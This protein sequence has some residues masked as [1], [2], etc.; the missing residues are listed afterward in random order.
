MNRREMIAVSIVGAGASFVPAK[1]SK[2]ASR[3][4]L[5]SEDD[6]R[7]LATG[8]T[9]WSVH[10]DFNFLIH[11]RKASW[12]EALEYFAQPI[13]K[14][15]SKYY[16]RS[17]YYPNTELSPTE[18]SASYIFSHDVCV[19]QKMYSVN[20]HNGIGGGAG[21][22]LHFTPYLTVPYFRRIH[23]VCVK[24]YKDIEQ[25]IKQKESDTATIF[26]NNKPDV[27]KDIV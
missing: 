1:I 3:S 26:K 18:H 17:K 6:V 25:I 11:Y 8:E 16:Q 23:H 19:I 10:E 12:E 2:A 27:T 14:E 4:V 24:N 15:Q 7:A 5:L 22:F 9:F 21:G 20:Q 13:E